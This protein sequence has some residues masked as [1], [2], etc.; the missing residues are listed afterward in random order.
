MSILL[1]STLLAIGGVGLYLYKNSDKQWS[2]NSS[3]E[4]DE[5]KLFKNDEDDEDSELSV[6]KDEFIP[7]SESQEEYKHKKQNKTKRNKRNGG[8]KRRYYY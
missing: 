6:E 4:Y 7:A 1:A 2:E 3:V 5:T 8:T